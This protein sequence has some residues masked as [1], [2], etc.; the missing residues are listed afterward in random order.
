[1]LV[2]VTTPKLIR[3]AFEDWIADTGEDERKILWVIF[4][5]FMDSR[6]AHE[7]KTSTRLISFTY[8]HWLAAFWRWR[9]REILDHPAQLDKIHY[10]T[11][12][13]CELLQSD[14]GQVYKLI[15]RECLNETD[16][17]LIEK[18]DLFDALVESVRENQ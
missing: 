16:T 3:Q 6:E 12:R 9:D 10:Y 5:S 1:M 13:L 14:F 2:Y 7:F 15:V 17:P 8:P 18:P 4:Q 11:R